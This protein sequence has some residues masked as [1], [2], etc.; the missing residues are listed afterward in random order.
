MGQ[1]EGKPDPRPML[2]QVLQKAKAMA[3]EAGIDFEELV[4][5]VMGESPEMEE[6]EGSVRPPSPSALGSM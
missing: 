1:G 5:E 6:G 3:D 2:V 4:N